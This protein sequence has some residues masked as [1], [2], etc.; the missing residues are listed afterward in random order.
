MFTKATFAA[1]AVALTV[2]MAVASTAP[3]AAVDAPVASATASY[4]VA[5]T[6]GM[7]NRQDRRDDRQGC[8]SSN[9]AVGHDKR[10]CKQDNRKHG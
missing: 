7:D 5:D 4:E 3:V 1:V 6:R 10:V 2:S 8:R 9:G